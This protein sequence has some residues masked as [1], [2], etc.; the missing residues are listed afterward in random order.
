MRVRPSPCAPMP[1]EVRT[2]VARKPHNSQLA[3][4]TNHLTAIGLNV[5]ARLDGWMRFSA[6]FF[7]QRECRAYQPNMRERLREVSQS[8]SCFRINLFSKQAEIAPILQEMIKKIIGLPQ[9]AAAER[10]ILYRPE[11]ANTKS[12]LCRL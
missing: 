8:V 4:F 1:I 3:Q 11:A 7:F 5:L 2:M 9:S 10:E 6:F 12:S